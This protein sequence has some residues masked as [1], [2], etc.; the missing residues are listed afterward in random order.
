[1]RV[2]VV[3]EQATRELRRA[4]LRPNLLAGDGL[5]GDDVVGAVH[6]AA[7]DDDATVVGTCFVAPWLPGR[8]AWRLRQM[9]TDPQRRGEGIG[10]AVLACAVD[11]ALARGAA[12]LWCE[13]REVAVSFYANHGFRAHGAMFLDHELG[14]PHLLMWREVAEPDRGVDSSV[15]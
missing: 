9:A 12:V 13:A 1:M 10:A 7:C 4:V 11:V 5:P 3:T 15:G 8:V 2:G 14:I 6:V